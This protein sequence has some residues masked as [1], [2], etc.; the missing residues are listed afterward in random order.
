MMRMSDIHSH[1]LQK[2]RQMSKKNMLICSGHSC[3]SISNLFV[4]KEALGQNC[5]RLN[6][7]I[8]LEFKNSEALQL[9]YGQMKVRHTPT[10]MSVQDSRS[11]RY[12]VS[13]L[14]LFHQNVRR[15]Q[16]L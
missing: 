12:E 14:L 16:L 11:S 10:A 1:P 15:E 6:W 2:F 4:D 3:I 9:F 7:D 13:L 8:I 5:D